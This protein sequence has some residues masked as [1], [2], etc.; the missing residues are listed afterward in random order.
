MSFYED[1]FDGRRSNRKRGGVLTPLISAIIGG[2][3]VL[4]LMPALVNSGI[5]KLTPK[6]ETGQIS[7]P[8]QPSQPGETKQITVNVTSAIQQAAQKARPAVVGVVNLR[9]QINFWNQS[10]KNVEA[11][12]GSGV[13]FQKQNG[14][15][16]IITNYHVIEGATGVE[17]ALADGKRVKAE[18]LG[19]DPLTDLAVLAIDDQYVDVVATLG[20]STTLKP[21][22]PAIAIGNPLGLEFSQTVTVG[23][24][25]SPLRTIEK[26]LD[27]DGQSDWETEVIQTDAAINPGNSGGALLNID[28]DVIGINSSKIAESGVEGLGFAIP[29]SDAKPIINDL[30]KYGKV[31]RSYMGITPVDLQMVSQSDRVNVL[32]LPSSVEEGVVI[33]DIK[34]TGPAALAGLRR[35]DV[36]VK[37]DD[38]PIKNSSDL[39]KYLYKVKHVGERMKVT[40]YREGKQ[41]TI[42]MTLAEFPDNQ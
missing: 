21:G 19:A 27:G 34:P 33:Y 12:V 16:Y 13:V 18:I 22:E 1:D 31:K 20:D 17:V 40:F 29:I 2:L 30:L 25:S 23:V 28:G 6:T 37:L 41:Q 24:I 4:L 26:D 42:E 36:I 32:K 15:A 5:I 10:T 7:G 39:R 8:L 3:I 9:K 14:K 35:L 11:G 38:Q